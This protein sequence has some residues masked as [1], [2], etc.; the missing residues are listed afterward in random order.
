MHLVVFKPEDI[1]LINEWLVFRKKKPVKLE[2]LPAIGFIAKK[3]EDLIAAGFLRKCEGIGMIDSIVSNPVMSS[4]LR[5]E[6]LDMIFNR[7]IH[8]SELHDIKILMGTSID[9]H[10][11]LRS[12]RFGFQKSPMS[13]MIR[14]I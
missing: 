9:D 11:I 2:E 10:T 1:S 5:N 3:D 8:V 13:L 4:A 14:G 7:L 6:A 12:E